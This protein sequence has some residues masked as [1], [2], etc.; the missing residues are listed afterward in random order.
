MHARFLIIVMSITRLAA[1]TLI[2]PTALVAGMMTFPTTCTCGADYPHDHPLY[3]IAGHH[4]G[5]QQEREPGP[6]GEARASDL[7]GVSIQAPTTTA[8]TALQ[9]INATAQ[10][11]QPLPRASIA[12][13]QV[14]ITDG[15]LEQPDV[16]PPQSRV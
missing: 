2:V 7:H 8:S 11:L 5:Q 4:H 15:L 14:I 10:T 3:G 1:G 13:E 6:H 12:I 9:A 16:P